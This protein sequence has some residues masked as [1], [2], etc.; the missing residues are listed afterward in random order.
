MAKV[1]LTGPQL[2]AKIIHKLLGNQGYTDIALEGNI[3]HIL[4]NTNPEYF[5]ITVEV[6]KKK[7]EEPSEEG[8]Q[9]I[10]V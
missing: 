7:K 4:K 5:K 2:V 6:V 3:V 9:K 8:H 1:S 10:P